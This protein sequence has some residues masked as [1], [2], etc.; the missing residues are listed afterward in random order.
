MLGARVLLKREGCS[1]CQIVLLPPATRR[2]AYLS[3]GTKMASARYIVF[4]VVTAL[5]FLLFM[6]AS[7]MKLTPALNEELHNEMVRCV[8]RAP[9][10][11]LY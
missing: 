10:F 11:C 6:F 2:N 9:C 5:L 7:I 3:P 8:L 4:Q 1:C